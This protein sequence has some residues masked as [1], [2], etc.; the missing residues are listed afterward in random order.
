ME[1][2]KYGL[3]TSIA[4]ITGIVIGSGIFFKS[5]NILIEVNGNIISGVIAFIAA[6]VSIIFGSL[7]ISQLASRTDRPGGI[8]T[9]AEEFCSVN[10]GCVFGWF[11]SFLYIPSIIVVVAW[12]S[13]V[14]TCIL[15]GIND[16]LENQMLIGIGFLLVLGIMNLLSAK[17]GGYFQNASM[18]IKLIPLIFV[19]V[20]GILYGKESP[21]SFSSLQEGA[22]SAGF[23]GAIPAIAFSFDGWTVSTSICHE[24]KNSKRNLPIALVV[25][26]LLILL[27]YILYFVGSCFLL[28]TDKIIEMGDAHVYEI[29]NLLFGAIGAKLLLILVIISVLGTLNGLI[30][31]SYRLPYAMSLRGM[32][33]GYKFLSKNAEGIGGVPL[34]SAVFSFIVAIIWMMFH[35]I[36]QKL[37][38][39]PNSDVSEISVVTNYATYIILYI[40][41]I[42]LALKGE[43]KGIFNGYILP[44]FAVIGAV[45]IIFAGA[46]SPFFIYYSL[47]CL[48]VIAAAYM[49]SVKNKERIIQSA[50]SAHN[51]QAI[52]NL[53]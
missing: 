37:N 30:L 45:I 49:Y 36:T 38:M 35:Y 48:A 39:L 43:I 10:A 9:Y 29:F 5:D 41:V 7:T 11:Q 6:A 31:G 2:R 52:V 13:G 53:K 27:L 15:F 16:T 33:P 4:M 24:I 46:G 23:I 12:V 14:Y 42:R 34:N 25:S 32:I 19:A 40:S 17:L 8:I 28:G 51:G 47:F 44:A 22:G 18:I 20:L 26:P 1:T 21:S 3:L 50:N